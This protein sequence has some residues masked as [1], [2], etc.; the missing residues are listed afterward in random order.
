MNRTIRPDH[1]LIR[2]KAFTLIELLIVVAIIAILAAIAVP[3]FL[4]AQTRSKI[5]RVLADQK[6]IATALESYYVDWNTY[7][8]DGNNI[9][10]PEGWIALTSPV[11]YI[12]TFF[13]D[14][15][16]DTKGNVYDIGTGNPEDPDNLLKTY[17]CTVWAISSMG[18]D[19]D[20]ST[21]STIAYPFTREACPYDPTNGAKSFGDIYRFGGEIKPPPNFLA[22]ENP[23]VF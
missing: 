3:N 7:P 18:P 4:E 1:Y 20:D 14:P 15:F 5:S 11:A 17:P 6:T 21:V 10:Y 12:T 9:Y 8:I 19:V 23:E 2:A 22:A 13:A 16:H